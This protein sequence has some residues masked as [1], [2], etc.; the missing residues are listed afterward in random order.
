M[1]QPT[2]AGLRPRMVDAALLGLL[3]GPAELVP[4]SSSGHVT[5]VPWLIGLPYAKLTP[6]RRKPVEVALHLGT[7]AALV[8]FPPKS[9][10]SMPGPAR[11]LGLDSLTLLPTAIAGLAAR[12]LITGRL[13]TPATVAAGLVG[14]SIALLTAD[15]LNGNRTATE[16]T[17]ADALAIGAIQS[18]A[19]W[20]GVSRSAMTLLG[21]RKRGFRAADS[22]RISRSGIVPAAAAASLLEGAQAL[23]SGVLRRDAAALATAA[24]TAFASTIAARAVATRFE[25]SPRLASWA[26]VRS[27]TAALTILR[28][29]ST[30]DDAYQ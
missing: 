12:R 10:V 7:A 9:A 13:G 26:V 16:L 6:E 23:R 20:P 24:A 15:R 30:G 18:A 28:I 27:A 4:I 14:G 5:L 25:S 19:L 29:R 17:A 11:M 21:A 1:P 22:A 8:A 3:H 2:D